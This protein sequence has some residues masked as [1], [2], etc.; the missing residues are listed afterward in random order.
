M[1]FLYLITLKNFSNNQDTILGCCTGGFYD[2]SYRAPEGG[3]STFGD[4]CQVGRCLVRWFPAQLWR[5]LE[6]WCHLCGDR[7]PPGW[8]LGFLM[9]SL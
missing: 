1:T 8:I 7:S 5:S 4:K 6:N 2:S 9:P 3:V